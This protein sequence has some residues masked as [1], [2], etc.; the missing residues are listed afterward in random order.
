MCRTIL[1]ATIL[2]LAFTPPGM[3]GEHTDNEART[4]A[5]RFL[6]DKEKGGMAAVISDTADCYRRA[7]NGEG[8]LDLRRCMVFDMVGFGIDAAMSKITPGIGV[9]PYY[10]AQT[11]SLR[12]GHYGPLAKFKDATE[13]FAFLKPQVTAVDSEIVR[14]KQPQPASKGLGGSSYPVCRGVL[15]TPTLVYSD[16]SNSR[17]IGIFPNNSVFVVVTG[18]ARAGYLPIVLGKHGEIHGWVPDTGFEPPSLYLHGH[19]CRI[20]RMEAGNYEAF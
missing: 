12:I 8:T 4:L 16:P 3:A 15:D 7:E 5:Q 19:T 10:D 1:I 18:P 13:A 9:L 6:A 20:K 17:P 14:L 11:V 2:G